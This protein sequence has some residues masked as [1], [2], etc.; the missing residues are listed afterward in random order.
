MLGAVIRSHGA[1][2]YKYPKVTED[3]ARSGKF[4]QLKIALIADHYTTRCLAEECRIRHVTP[5]NYREVLGSWRPDLLLAESVFHGLGGCWRYRVGKQPKYLRF[6][7]PRTIFNVI[8]YA[9]SQGIPTVFWNKDDGAFFDHFV[10]VAKAFEYIFTSDERCVEKYRHHVSD[11]TAVN[12]LSIPYQPQFH[13]F[14]GFNFNR[15]EACFVGSYYLRILN[16][17]RHFLDMVFDACEE[18]CFPINVYDRNQ[19]RFSRHFEFRFPQKKQLCLHNKIPHRQTAEVYKSHTVSINVNS[20]TDSETMYSR[21]LLEILAC[22]GIVVTNPGRAIDKYFR[23]YCHVV[24]S[25]EETL[26]LLNRLRQGLLQEDRDRA[27][28]GARYVRQNHTWEHRLE[29]LC[30]VVS[31]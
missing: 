23:D 17:R 21:R 14:T 7:K 26:E 18:S 6:S 28:A 10:D 3:I 22:G 2:V 12:T 1:L 9:R 20:V 27:A 25:R 30:A 15:N 19:G 4:G 16:E 8:K 13:N 29:E 11:E 24:K 5:R 31:V